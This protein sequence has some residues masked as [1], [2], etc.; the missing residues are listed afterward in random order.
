M[1]TNGGRVHDTDMRA[2]LTYHSIDTSGSPI[3]CHPDAFGRH[4]DWLSSGRVQLMTVEELLAAPPA[5]DAVAVTFDDAFLNFE[6]VAAPRLVDAGVQVTL[7]VVT[8]CTGTTNVWNGRP[9]RDVPRLPLLDWSSLRR[10]QEQGVAL[11]AHSRSHP[12]LTL[13]SS[14]ALADEIAGSADAIERNIGIRPSV[15][16]YPYGRVTQALA[17]VVADT[18]RFAC[19]TDFRTL[20]DTL[21]PAL[22]PRLDMYYFQRAGRLED[23]GTPR[24]DH[25]VRRR[26]TLRRLRQGLRRRRLVC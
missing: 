23:W 16:A 9:E 17:A 1:H 20:D 24:F 14:A 19:T 2:I 10:Q 4:L 7:F 15:F 13:L 22:L 18:F 6:T 12:D 11:G 26:R 21:V 3:S 8:G 5:L 25:Y